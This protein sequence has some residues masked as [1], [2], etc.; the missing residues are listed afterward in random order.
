M[1]DLGFS[2]SQAL[3]Y[4]EVLASFLFGAYTGRCHGKM[5]FNVDINGEKD[6]TREE[7]CLVAVIRE[8]RAAMRERAQRARER[9][10][11]IA[12][13]CECCEVPT[14]MPTHAL[15]RNTTWP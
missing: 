1:L 10:R 7:C 4:L 9:V 15:S 5:S 13:F 12:G 8:V 2:L 6:D 14:T 3:P 11:N